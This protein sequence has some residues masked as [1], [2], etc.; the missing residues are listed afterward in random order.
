MGGGGVEYRQRAEGFD[1]KG[2]AYGT[3]RR[4]ARQ[5]FFQSGRGGLVVQ[6]AQC[7]DRR[8][9]FPQW[10]FRVAGKENETGRGLGHPRLFHGADD[11]YP[12]FRVVHVEEWQEPILA[13]VAFQ[14][15]SGDQH[16]HGRKFYGDFF[17]LM[18]ADVFQSRLQRNRRVE[19]VVVERPQQTG[20]LS[21]AQVRVLEQGRQSIGGGARSHR[22]ESSYYFVQVLFHAG[23]GQGHQA[24]DPF[25]AQFLNGP[26]DA[27]GQTRVLARFE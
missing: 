18:R 5:D 20:P 13:L 7:L 25:L 23:V 4:R 10:P 14:K 21:D 19:L 8:D 2:G 22:F 24:V 27:V 17:F 9:P 1:V 15:G 11:R 6:D 26:H 16:F 3:G 12:S